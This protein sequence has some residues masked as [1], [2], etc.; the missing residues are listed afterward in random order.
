MNW[1]KKGFVFICILWLA[2]CASTN[3]TEP[4]IEPIDRFI[5]NS[6]LVI[7]PN[8][9]TVE[10]NAPYTFLSS[11]TKPLAE[12]GYYV[13]P[14]A[15]IDT[16]LKQNGL[17]TPAEMNTIPLDKIQ[18]IIG[19][20]SVLYVQINDWGQKYQILQSVTVVNAQ[21]KLVE[22]ETG[23]ILWQG[24]ASAR[25]GSNQS[26]NGLAEML[27]GAIVEQVI[28][29]IDDKTIQ[30]SRAANNRV[31]FDKRTG[32]PEGIYR[33]LKQSENTSLTAPKQSL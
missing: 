5:P 13:F 28:N 33:R 24:T 21:L 31:I 16:F 22:T 8:N 10:V 6:I 2:S 17:P 20:E 3:R 23:D 12:K 14:V 7:P 15:V 29:S 32:L 25:S 9:N 19:A 30:L 1:S 26:Q 11:I 27:I 18:K 4:F